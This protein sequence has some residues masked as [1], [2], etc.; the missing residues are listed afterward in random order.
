[1]WFPTYRKF[2]L[3]DK[4]FARAQAMDKECRTDSAGASSTKTRE[5][6]TNRSVNPRRRGPH[7]NHALPSKRREIND[8]MMSEYAVKPF[9][10]KCATTRYVS[11][12]FPPYVEN[13]VRYSK[14]LCRDVNVREGARVMCIANLEMIGNRYIVNGSQGT[15]SEI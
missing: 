12:S 6:L 7:P 1:M 11:T 13:E 5:M 2:R 8:E 3:S 15:V 9:R 10:W 4:I 14:I